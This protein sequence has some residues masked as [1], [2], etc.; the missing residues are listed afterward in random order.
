MQK[1]Y[2]AYYSR[3]IVA[4]SWKAGKE[5]KKTEFM[6][7]QVIDVSGV[8][9][10]STLQ[11]PFDP[12]SEQIYVNE[13]R[14]MDRAG[15]TLAAGKPSDYYV[16]DDHLRRMATQKKILNIPVPGL[17][18]GCQI[19]LMITSREL[20]RQDEFPFLEHCFSRHLPVRESILFLSGDTA[21]LKHRCSES[22]EP[23]ASKITAM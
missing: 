7:G 5:H 6:V 8:A 10:F 22:L 16:L 14:V 2:G 12:L 11:I 3:R 19:A 4:V 18:P 15:K 21:G 9:A 23:E 1:K 13:L 17:E 20:G